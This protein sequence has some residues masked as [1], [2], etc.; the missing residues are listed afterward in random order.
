MSEEAEAF[1]VLP[2]RE[3]V[4]LILIVGIRDPKRQRKVAGN[5]DAPTGTV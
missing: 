1:F 2:Q 3:A 4:L 5:N